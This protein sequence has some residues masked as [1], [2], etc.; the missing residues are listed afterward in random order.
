MRQIYLGPNHP[1]GL[2]VRS[3]IYKNGV[4]ADVEALLA[5][6]PSAGALLVDTA[7]A[8]A[9]LAGLR[10]KDSACGALYASAEKEFEEL[11]KEG[12]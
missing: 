12:I 3:V 8:P 7:E 9:V 11:L 6:C 5:A 10:D 4:P 1:K 2:I